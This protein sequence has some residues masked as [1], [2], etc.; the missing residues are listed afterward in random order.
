MNSEKNKWETKGRKNVPTGIKVTSDIL[1][2]IFLT[3]LSYPIGRKVPELVR[4][5]NTKEKCKQKVC[6]QP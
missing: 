3:I 5:L 6:I 1:F 2:S 4:T